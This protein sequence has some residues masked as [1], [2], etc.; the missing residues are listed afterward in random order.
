M[1][2]LLY[3]Q[4]A[5]A[6]ARPEPFFGKL[7]EALGFIKD[8]D[9]SLDDVKAAAEVIDAN[10]ET[11]AAAQDA[12]NDNKELVDSVL[13]P[14]NIDTAAAVY[15]ENKQAADSLVKSILKFIFPFAKAS[16]QNPFASFFTALVENMKASEAIKDSPATAAVVD[17]VTSIIGEMDSDLDPF[18]AAAKQANDMA[19][20][21]LGSAVEAM[22]NL[23]GAVLNLFMS[24]QSRS[25]GSSISDVFNP[26]INVVQDTVNL[27]TTVAT[28]LVGGTQ[29]TVT[30]SVDQAM[31][32]FK[33]IK[34]DNGFIGTLRNS[35]VCAETV[36]NET[37]NT[38]NGIADILVNEISF[39]FMSAVNGTN[40]RIAGEIEKRL[41]EPFR[42]C[43][44]GVTQTSTM[45][46]QKLDN[47]IEGCVNTEVETV[48]NVLLVA[49]NAL[50][51]TAGLVDAVDRMSHDCMSFRLISCGWA[52]RN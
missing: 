22:P 39:T 37:Y 49:R 4:Q 17:A 11:I 42:Q 26:L 43:G 2:N 8:N 12:Y 6:Q 36:L 18:N 3:P 19:N 25:I 10:Q 7:F 52:V 34:S 28:S 9:I 14:E 31:N 29:K 15:Q 46:A 40:G 32:C 27:I 1:N 33:T 13:T 23:M 44:L 45:V 50:G 41:P 20:A 16:N 21:L 48:L 35:L 5:T 30:N 51:V 47:E 38:A 24:T